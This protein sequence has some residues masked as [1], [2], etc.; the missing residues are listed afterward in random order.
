MRNVRA[1]TSSRSAF[2]VDSHSPVVANVESSLKVV[3]EVS[4]DDDFTRQDVAARPFDQQT[5]RSEKAWLTIFQVDEKQNHF[6][7]VSQ[8]HED[9]LMESLQ[10]NKYQ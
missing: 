9:D 8:K 7:N 10:G 1:S 6:C 5:Y 3:A 2:L 4:I